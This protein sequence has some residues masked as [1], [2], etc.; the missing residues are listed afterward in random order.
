MKGKH[1]TDLDIEGMK[2][3]MKSKF[4]RMN[5]IPACAVTP[6]PALISFEDLLKKDKEREKD[7]FKR[8]IKIRKILA[9]SDRIIVVPYAEEEKLVHGGVKPQNENGD[10]GEEVGHGDYAVGDVIGQFPLFGEDGDD[11]DGDEG[12]GEGGKGD[13]DHSIESAAYELGKELAERFQLPNLKDK[14]KKV[15]TNEY[16][17][18]LTD[19]HQGS[20]QVL[21]KK[22]T[23]KKIVTTNIA[24][25]R[26]DKD[27][28]DTSKLIAAPRDKIFRV[29]SREKVWKS[30]AIV[31]FVR[32][33]SG[34]MWGEPTKAIVNQHL[35]IYAWLLV[36]YE[37]LVV[38]RFIV[39][40][41]DAHEVTVDDYFTKKASGGT[42]IASAYKKINEIVE[43]EALE[44]DYNIYVFQGTD[45]EDGDTADGDAA[46]PELRKILRYVNRMGVSVLRHAAY[47]TSESRFEEYLKKGGILDLT[48]IFRMHSMPSAGVTEEENVEAIRTIISQD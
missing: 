34:S 9:G 22:A 5:N 33:Y 10:L 1:V 8:K 18:D 15:P 36:Q 47:G 26:L 13:E 44:R 38:P 24:L 25:G 2:L 27:A 30:Q 39:H 6:M 40:D 29:L 28:V 43:G 12:E 3:R 42:Y 16:I 32:D 48:D 17:Y 23:L 45:G 41:H 7:G 46:L 31:F 20:G 35:M 21:D 19:K 4:G 11:G 37:K 14:G